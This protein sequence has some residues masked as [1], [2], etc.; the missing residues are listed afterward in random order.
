M[1]SQVSMSGDVY[2]FGIFLLEMFTGKRPTDSMFHNELNLHDFAKMSLPERVMEI[3]EPS[4]LLEVTTDNNSFENFARLHGEGRVRME[5]C[6][7][8]ALRIGVLCSMESPTDRIEMTDVVA[9]L[10]AIMRE[11]F[12]S[13]R[14]GDVRPRFHL[15][16]VVK[17]PKTFAKTLETRERENNQRWEGQEGST[18]NRERRI[19]WRF[20]VFKPAFTLPPKLRSLVDE[21]PQWDDQGT[22]IRNYKFFGFISNPNFLGVC[23][24]TSNV[25]ESDSPQLPPSSEEPASEFDPT[26][27]GSDLEGD[28]NTFNDEP[29]L[30]DFAKTSLP[31]RVM[32]IV[33]PSPLLEVTTDNN[34]VENFARF[35]GQGRVR[36]EEYLVGVLRMGVLCSMVSPADRI[37]MADMTLPERVTEIVEP[38]LL[39]EVGAGINNNVENYASRQGEGSGRIEECLVAVLKILSC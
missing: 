21:L 39:L 30:Y 7:V 8:G 15:F 13:R 31:E 38:S 36:M 16:Y 37:E 33:E 26:D 18:S 22:V 9:K 4:L 24:R 6:L 14:T 12:L 34:N 5:E 17:S 35:H 25:V 10:C 32:E 1:G 2:S 28:D 19:E 11:N 29:T 20:H 23:S 27:S 3:A